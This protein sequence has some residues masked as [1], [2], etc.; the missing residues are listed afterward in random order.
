LAQL[1]EEMNDMACPIE[2]ELMERSTRECAV[3]Q[4]HIISMETSV[5]ILR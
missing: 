4:D 5:D 2:E 1:A 3:L